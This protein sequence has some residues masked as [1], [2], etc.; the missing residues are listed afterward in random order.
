MLGKILSFGVLSAVAL[1]T[2]GRVVHMVRPGP[3]VPRELLKTWIHSYEEDQG[4]IRVYR[5][6]GFNFPPSFGREGFSILRGGRFV[7]YDIG[8][9]DGTVE[10]PGTWRLGANHVLLV[11][12]RRTE[13]TEQR[14]Y[15]IQI[16]SLEA[17]R[18]KLRYL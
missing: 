13:T 10:I 8:P 16:I 1:L 4:D 15:R 12:L 11:T 7:Q 2:A 9:A 6:S 18:I 17:D 3:Q 14:T 5:P